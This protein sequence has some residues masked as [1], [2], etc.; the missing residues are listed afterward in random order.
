MP[1]NMVERRHLNVESSSNINLEVA[2]ALSIPRESEPCQGRGG[3][4][5][6]SRAD[7]CRG[8]PYGFALVIMT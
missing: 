4:L 8:L 7:S 2:P 1:R 3:R 6:A 5:Q